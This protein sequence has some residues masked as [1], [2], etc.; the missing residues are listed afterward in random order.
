MRKSL[1]ISLIIVTVAVLVFG[2][3]FAKL[4]WFRPLSIDHFF[5]RA[6]IDFLWNDPEALTQTGVL[7]PF[8]FQGY[9]SELTFI[10]PAA[11]RNLAE[12]GRANLEI[13]EEYDRNK[14][15]PAQMVSYDVLHWF[16]ETGVEAEPFLFHD[17][18]I[19]HISGAHIE[20]PQFMNSLPL[21]SKNEIEN[22]LSRLEKV[23]EKFGSVIDAL[24]ERQ[25]LGFVPPTHILQKSIAFCDN[26]YETPVSENPLFVSF[27][28]KLNSI[29]LLEP[30]M[31]LSYLERCA[32][33]I[34]EVVIPSYKRLSGYLLQLEH[35]SLAIAGVWQLPNGDAYYRSCLL[36]QTTLPLDPDSLYQLGRME[37]ERLKSLLKKMEVFATGS[38][39]E[40]FQT[41]S[42]GRLEAIQYFKKASDDIKPLLP[43]YFNKLP[44]TELEVLEL[45]EYRSNNSTFALYISP[46]GEPLSPGKMYVNTWKANNLT[47]HLA[48]TYAYHEGIPGHHLQKGIQADLKDIPTFRRFVPFTAYSEGW[49]MYA[50]QLGHEMTGTLMVWDKIGQVQSELFRTARM[51]TDIG[52]HHKKWLREQA[53]DFMVENAGISESEAADEVD[54]YIVW[55]GQGCAYKVGLMKFLELRERAESRIPAFDIKEF[56]DVLIGQGA[57]PL[58][59]LEQ[60]VDEYISSKNGN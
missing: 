36:Q 50:E 47:K 38:N 57:M 26:F 34:Q 5:E 15:E 13:L 2:V 45:P 46:R 53:I 1:T 59:I 19:T 44:S 28:K 39:A 40:Y 7:D 33:T 14:L 9:R 8:G 56:H 20:L 11:T 49:A 54:R 52:I 29:E 35:H 16:L 4:I 3:W 43:S 12:V 22:Y 55:P 32:K 10:S 41:D 23:D 48:K 18:P 27:E 51:M 30:N 31:R 37:M 21:N 60:R 42:F 58:Q 25:K 17:Y 24:S 6:Y